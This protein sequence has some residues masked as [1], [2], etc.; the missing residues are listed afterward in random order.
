MRIG[1]TAS[2]ALLTAAILEFAL[3]Y[4]PVPLDRLRPAEINANPVTIFR[5]GPDDP[6]VKKSR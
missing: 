3:L 2:V 5:K 6:K 4:E 1:R